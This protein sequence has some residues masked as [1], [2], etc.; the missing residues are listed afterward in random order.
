M[1][2]TLN[3]I[4]C[5]EDDSTRAP[6]GPWSEMISDLAVKKLCSQYGVTTDIAWQLLK[7]LR[8]QEYDE[9]FNVDSSSGMSTPSDVVYYSDIVHG[10]TKI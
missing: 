3:Q 10:T 1:P 7:E 2:R 9:H 6:C 4:Y 5:D 8:K